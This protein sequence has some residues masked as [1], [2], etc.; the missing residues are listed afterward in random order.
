MATIIVSSKH[1]DCHGPVNKQNGAAS[2][3]TLHPS[4][5]SPCIRY[6]LLSLKR[7]KIRSNDTDVPFPWPFQL[8][9]LGDEL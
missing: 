6:K 4:L 3:T 8:L 5:D 9:T 7:I 1:C 2:P